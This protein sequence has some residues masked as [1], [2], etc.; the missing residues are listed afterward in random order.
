[1]QD[2][3]GSTADLTDGSGNVT[4]GYG[5]DVFG[6]IR[7]QSGSS[8]NYWLFTGEQLDAECGTCNRPPAIMTP[9]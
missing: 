6:T 2:C 4:A 8:A 9:R 3:L 1:M 5:Y 7:S